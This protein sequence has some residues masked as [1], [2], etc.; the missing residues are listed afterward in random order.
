MFYH[1]KWEQL[2]ALAAMLLLTAPAPAA[3]GVGKLAHPSAPAVSRA[4]AENLFAVP[5]GQ[6]SIAFAFP[7]DG[8]Y[9]RAHLMCRLMQKMGYRPAKIWAFANGQSLHVRTANHPSGHVEW[10]YHVAPILRVRVSAR[11]E[12]DLVFD[13]ALFRGPVTVAR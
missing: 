13:P 11:E 9:A 6:K 3:P 8:C 12:R 5:A 1:R 7:L 4:E 10:G 2:A